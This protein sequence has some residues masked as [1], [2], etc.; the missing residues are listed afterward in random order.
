M[1]EKLITN[2][3]LKNVLET[4]LPKV[5]YGVFTSNCI[6]VDLFQTSFRSRIRLREPNADASSVRNY[7]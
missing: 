7:D 1:L 2:F 3:K 5:I 6:G 4:S